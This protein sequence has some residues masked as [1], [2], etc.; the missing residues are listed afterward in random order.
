MF[1]NLW[2]VRRRRIFRVRPLSRK[3]VWYWNEEKYFFYFSNVKDIRKK[4]WVQES[5]VDT[6]PTSNLLDWEFADGGWF[7]RNHKSSQIDVF[8]LLLN[9]SPEKLSYDYFSPPIVVDS[10]V[11]NTFSWKHTKKKFSRINVSDLLPAKRCTFLVSS[12]MSIPK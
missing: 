11:Q 6:E 9:D 5:C 1:N 3:F 12:A 7:R 2:R 10:I 4:R 8:S